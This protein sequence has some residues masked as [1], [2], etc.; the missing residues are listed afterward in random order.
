MAQHLV[1]D[2]HPMF[3]HGFL[4]VLQKSRASGSVDV[5]GFNR[6]NQSLH[7]HHKHEDQSWFPGFRRKRVDLKAYIDI[8]ESD[9]AELVRLERSVQKGDLAALELFCANL[10]DHLNR[11]EMMGVPSFMDN[12]AG[13]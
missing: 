2:V 6:I 13:F 1:E 5:A 7:G 10:F 11:E 4:A 9:H 12:T 8:L 3:R